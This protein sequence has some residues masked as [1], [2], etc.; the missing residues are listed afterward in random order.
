[1]IN[2]IK[3]LHVSIFSPLSPAV[4]TTQRYPVS[5][6]VCV[7]LGL[8]TYRLISPPFTSSYR[9]FAKQQVAMVAG[10]TGPISSDFTWGPE[11][12]YACIVWQL[13]VI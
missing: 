11:G 2:L 13:A 7:S 12:G 10:F 9:G 3:E 1:M 5:M 8:D 6:S 4:Q